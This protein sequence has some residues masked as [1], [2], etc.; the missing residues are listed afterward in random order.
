MALWYERLMQ[1]LLIPE[2]MSELQILELEVNNH[3]ESDKFN[4]MVK[5]QDY[6]LNKT[7]IEKKEQNIKWQSNAKIALGLFK[8]LVDQKV[9][10]LLSKDPSISYGASNENEQD[11]VVQDLLTEEVF[12][13][14][15]L[16][17]LKGIGRE[18]VVKGVAYAI[19]HYTEDGQ[20]KLTKIPSQQIIPFYSGS[21]RTYV[22]AFAR[23]YYQE[24]YKLNGKGLETCIE[25]W[26]DKGVL[27]YILR[28]GKLHPNTF[29]KGRQQPHF[30]YQSA[31]GQLQP[32]TWQRVPLI[33][34]RYNDDE[35]SLLE[36]VKPLID[37]LELQTSV[38]ADLLADLPKF[39]YVLK[40]YG[41]T[42]LA[43]FVDNLNRFKA[44]NVDEN[45]GIDKL[46]ANIDTVGVEAEIKR[47][48]KF[49]YEAARAIDTQ[50][51]NLGNAS[52][53]ALKWRYTDLDLDANDFE[54]GLQQSLKV[55]M[56]FVAQFIKATK[57]VDLELAKF[58]Y[59]FNRDMITNESEAIQDC[60]NSV[61][62]LDAQTIREQH[63]WYT[64][65]VE[66]R[67]AEETADS[68]VGG[69]NY[70]EE[71]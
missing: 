18:A 52:G 6:Y 46:Q 32:F 17:E 5:A 54:N 67:L 62:I 60:Q 49:L 71:E 35:Q 24:V 2:E 50:D 31:S 63:P 13:Q 22:D 7:D 11:K 70:V 28:N 36:Q 48:R 59:V 8:K 45:G 57:G 38:N 66:E 42:N 1:K 21:D 68:H 3:L 69:D 30:Y 65:K 9:G 61:G 47:S 53:Q 44:I 19:P 40:N 43:E 29:Y 64:D 25:Y 15:M 39:I 20:L 12:S 56:W 51:E 37:N 10:Y 16:R 26:T 34:F 23:V 55:F 58:G 4:M 33:V 41:G 27:H 14:E